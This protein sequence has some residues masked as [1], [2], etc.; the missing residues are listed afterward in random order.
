MTDSI[1]SPDEQWFHRCEVCSHCFSA[2]ELTSPCPGCGERNE[3]D[4]V[5]H[6][7]YLNERYGTMTPEE[8]ATT[9]GIEDLTNPVDTPDDK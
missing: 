6:D 5:S 2:A 8:W 7:Y 9:L 4:T 3:R 1:S